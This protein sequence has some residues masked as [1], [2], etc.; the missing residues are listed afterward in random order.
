MPA[1]VTSLH[2]PE[3]AWSS[4]KAPSQKSLAIQDGFPGIVPRRRF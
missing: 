2:E 4:F 1:T 3:A